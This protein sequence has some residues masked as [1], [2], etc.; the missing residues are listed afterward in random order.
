[1]EVRRSEF[2]A[3]S[4]RHNRE[5][6]PYWERAGNEVTHRDLLAFEC[7]GVGWTVDRPTIEPASGERFE[8]RLTLVL[9]REDGA[10]KIVHAH[11]S[12][13]QDPE[14]RARGPDRPAGERKP[15]HPVDGATPPGGNG[16]EPR[17]AARY[18]ARTP[19]RTLGAWPPA[20]W[21]WTSL[22]ER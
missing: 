15:P 20:R 2:W 11:T 10:R 13:G 19:C 18:L 14:D 3:D 9:H 1:M 17:S 5:V 22:V 7:G 21:S 6:R 12:V 8:T 4:A 16:P